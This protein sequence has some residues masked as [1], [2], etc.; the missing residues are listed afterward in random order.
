[1]PAKFSHVFHLQDHARGYYL[2]AVNLAAQ[3]M[4]MDQRISVSFDHKPTQEES[5]R[6][7]EEY[8]RR[9]L[10][11]FSADLDRQANTLTIT[12]SRVR[13]VRLY[14]MDGMFD[15]A[16]PVSLRVGGRTWKGLVKASAE[17][18]L[19]HYADDRDVSAVIVNEVDLDAAG[20]TIIRYK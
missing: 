18:M 6:K 14:V 7:M 16:R 13:T 20:R 5:D 15:L 1:M 19:K 2:E 4:R 11:G 3:P 12:L 8:F 17:C 9:F 10:F